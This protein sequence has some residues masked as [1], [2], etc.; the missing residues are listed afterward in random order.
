MNI[1]TGTLEDEYKEYV[2]TMIKNNFFIVNQEINVGSV[3]EALDIAEKLEKDTIIFMNELH[4]I[5][6]DKKGFK[7]I[8]EEEKSH[9]FRIYQYK[10]EHGLV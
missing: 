5:I 6:D 2:S 9:L 8:L 10:E 1:E 7:V 3:K 4:G